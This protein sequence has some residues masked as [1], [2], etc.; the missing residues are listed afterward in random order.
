MIPGLN[1][2][3][4]IDGQNIDFLFTMSCSISSLMKINMVNRH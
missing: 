4:A 2:I 3:F 1:A